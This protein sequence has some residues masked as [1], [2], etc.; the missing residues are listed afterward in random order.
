MTMKSRPKINPDYTWFKLAIVKS[1]IHRYGVV[2]MENIPAHKYVIEYTGVLHNRKMSK[3]MD[4]NVPVKDLIYVW[5]IPK[6]EHFGVSYWSLDG[7]TG[8]S[9]AEIVNHS[10]NPNLEPVF[11]GRRLYYYSLRPIKKGEE[12]TID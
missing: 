1:P 5:N 4:E 3:W 6:N 8:G 11:K 2:A 12:L 7:R 9:G 10:C